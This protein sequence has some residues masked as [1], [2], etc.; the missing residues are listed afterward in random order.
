MS[1]QMITAFD[2]YRIEDFQDTSD[3]GNTQNGGIKFHSIVANA[4]GVSAQ[5]SYDIV[6]DVAERWLGEV[7]A[8]GGKLARSEVVTVR[9]DPRLRYLANLVARKQRRTLS[10]FIEWAIEESLTREN[11]ERLL[12]RDGEFASALGRR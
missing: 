6:K 12:N 1:K 7:K 8:G 9:L 11:A 4:G 3:P 5:R 2:K 10:S